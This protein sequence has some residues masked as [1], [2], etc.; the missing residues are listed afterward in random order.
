MDTVTHG[1][2]VTELKANKQN[3]LQ[4]NNH[5]PVCVHMIVMSACVRRS[6]F[7]SMTHDIIPPGHNPYHRHPA[8][9]PAEED[10]L[11]DANDMQT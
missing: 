9:L 6:T 2:A 3:D 4:Y 5:G 7:T 10:E 8:S 11:D 1:M